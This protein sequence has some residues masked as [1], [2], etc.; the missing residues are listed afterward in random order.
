LAERPTDALL[1]ELADDLAPVR[2]IPR[3]RS[4][5]LAAIAGCGVMAGLNTWL[6]GWP[7]PFLA[8]GL[9]SRELSFVATLAG[10]ALAA[11]GALTAALAGAVPG[12]GVAARAGRWTAAIGVALALVG[13]VWWALGAGAMEKTM[14]LASCVGC[15][16]HAL[17]LAVAPALIVGLFIG[18]T[19]ARRPLAL[20][21]F[22][23][24]GAVALGAWLIHA[25]CTDTGALHVALGHVAGPLGLGLML[26]LPLTWLARRRHG[27]VAEARD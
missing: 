17:L 19:L 22:A 12:R 14:P 3:L 11:A 10:L 27:T 4:V 16:S 1:R 9:P 20:C 2:R 21:T 6:T 26:A 8:A 7:L 24:T 13:A 25:S 15:A 23:A 18:H 5:A